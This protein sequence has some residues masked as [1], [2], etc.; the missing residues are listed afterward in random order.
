SPKIK[1]VS[2]QEPIIFKVEP[3]SYQALKKGETFTVNIT[4]NNVNASDRLVGVEFRL[5]Y[6][7]T[8]L[9]VV[10]V[11]EGPFF[12]QFNQTPNP[13]YTFFIY[14]IEPETEFPNGTII[15]PHVLV[16]ILLLPNSTGGWPG[17][18]P[19]GNGTIAQITFKAIYQPV[20]PLPPANCTLDLF[21]VR[22]V[23]D[24]KEQLPVEEE[25]GYYEI[26]PALYPIVIYEYSPLMPVAGQKVIFNASKSYDPDGEILWYL[27]EF[28]DGTKINTTNPVI[29]YTFLSSGENLVTLTVK[30]I[31]GLYASVTK[32]IKVGAPTP[33]SISIET[34]SL[35]LQNETCEFSILVTYLG[36]PVDVDVISALLYFD[37]SMV[38]NLTDSVEW[39]TAGYYRI[40][41]IIPDGAEN[42]LYTLIVNAEYN[43]I[44]GTGI[45]SFLVSETLSN[46]TDTINEIMSYL[47]KDIMN[48][49]NELNDKL[50]NLNGIN[51]K[52]DSLTD[53]LNEISGELDGIY[54]KLDNT[55]ETMNGNFKDVK[56]AQNSMLTT[57]YLTSAVELG[58]LVIIAAVVIYLI[59]K[60]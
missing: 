4:I 41:Y 53:K 39:V 33:L 27:W 3:E 52:L 5:G 50:D 16:G 37:G 23:N 29:T 1:L 28:E 2:A 32:T 59:K 24:L 45:K 43:G 11:T 55:T 26:I 22:A 60:K 13:P 10:S 34:G 56:G 48:K 17:P 40:K 36:S 35:Y 30:D 57:F 8:L 25:D 49:L 47:M 14:Y 42:G 20:E 58:L 6:N 12:K 21:Q 46:V 7:D 19:Q 54:D 9:E 31:D 18:M 51:D 38:E 15:P 44:Y